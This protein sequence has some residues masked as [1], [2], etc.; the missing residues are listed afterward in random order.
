LEPGTHSGTCQAGARRPCHRIGDGRVVSASVWSAA[1]GAGQLRAVSELQS[2]RNRAPVSSRSWG[3][4]I[5]PRRYYE[6][7]TT[8]PK[9]CRITLAFSRRRRRSAGTTGYAA[10][11]EPA[12]PYRRRFAHGRTTSTSGTNARTATY[13]TTKPTTTSAATQAVGEATDA[14]RPNG[15]NATSATTAPAVRAGQKRV[16]Q[17]RHSKGHHRIAHQT[18]SSGRPCGCWQ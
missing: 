10:P 7:R 16:P 13:A 15:K 12:R 18:R 8:T 6:Q 1:K 11:G 5:D 17:L 14:R 2:H 3:P 4:A 9:S